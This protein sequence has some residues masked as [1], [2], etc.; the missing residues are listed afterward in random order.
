MPGWLARS[1]AWWKILEQDESGLADQ[2]P[3]MRLQGA[4]V[5]AAALALFAELAMIRWHATSAHVFAIFKNIS[6]L[7][8]FLGLGVGFAL[9][10][11]PR[12]LGLGTFLPLL[13]VQ[14]VLFGAIAST[15]GGERVN[16]VAEQLVMGLRTEK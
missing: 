15:I 6:L 5:L 16:P 7:S 11:R 2:V 14:V 4:V 8:C 10:S 13:T 9:A 1:T 12:L 3:A